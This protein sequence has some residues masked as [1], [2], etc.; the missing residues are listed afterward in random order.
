M[1]TPRRATPG[2]SPLTSA[3]VAQRRRIDTL[4]PLFWH[5]S[6]GGRQTTIVGPFFERTTPSSHAVGMVPLFLYAKNSQR[7]MTVVPPL[8]LFQRSTAD[9]TRSSFSACC[10]STTAIPAGR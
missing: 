9:G 2:S 10:S 5:S 6:F 1:P 8:L 3:C 4:L 7:T